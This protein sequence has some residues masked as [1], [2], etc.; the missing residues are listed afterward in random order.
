M[1]VFI[2]LVVEC[3]M[4]WK[5]GLEGK[6]G[7]SFKAW[8]EEDFLDAIRTITATLPHNH[9]TTVV[10]FSFFLILLL[11]VSLP[12]STSVCEEIA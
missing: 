4:P 5:E 7:E 3:D 2:F 10:S 11:G 8:T 9:L 1:L 6:Y 12:R